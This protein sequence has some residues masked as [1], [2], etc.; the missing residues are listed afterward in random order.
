LLIELLQVV[1]DETI[2]QVRREVARYAQRSSHER[3]GL[4]VLNGREVDEL[5][6]VLTICAML[7][8]K[9]SFLH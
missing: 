9:E 5:I 4:L 8:A 2:G 7:E 1:E 3:E 6:V